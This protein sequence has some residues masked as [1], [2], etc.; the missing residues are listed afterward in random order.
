MKNSLYKRPESQKWSSLSKLT[1]TCKSRKEPANILSFWSQ[2]GTKKE[3]LKFA[4][5]FHPSEKL[6]KLSRA[7]QSV[8]QT[9]T[10]TL[11]ALG[12]QT[13]WTL[14]TKNIWAKRKATVELNDKLW[15]AL[16]N[17]MQLQWQM[18]NQN[19]LSSNNSQM[20]H[21]VKRKRQTLW[22]T[23]I[24]STLLQAE[25][26][27]LSASQSVSLFNRLKSN[28]MTIH[29]DWWVLALAVVLNL[30]TLLFNRTMEVSIWVC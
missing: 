25:P 19:K 9:W 22:T 3:R 14:T 20:A 17:S 18:R 30:Q 1:V 12:Y 29:L 23:M 24:F 10:L 4:F 21:L 8:K 28:R 11:E 13:R 26:L 16:V 27:N 15:S 7:F 6:P 5:Q 2:C